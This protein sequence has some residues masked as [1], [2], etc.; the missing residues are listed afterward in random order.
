MKIENIKKGEKYIYKHYYWGKLRTFKVIIAD[1]ILKTKVKFISG[2]E[3]NA[4]EC[5][6][7][8]IYNEENLLEVKN[9]FKKSFISDTMGNLKSDIEGSVL[10]LEAYKE[11][12]EQIEKEM[13]TK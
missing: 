12:L 2:F 13:M 3:L 9:E 11:M 7:L 4:N 1:K 10:K 6:N 5:K 8:N